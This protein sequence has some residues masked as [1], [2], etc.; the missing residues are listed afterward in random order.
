MDICWQLLIIGVCSRHLFTVWILTLSKWRQ[1]YGLFVYYFFMEL[2]KCWAHWSGWGFCDLVKRHINLSFDWQVNTIW[3][4][5]FQYIMVGNERC[6][7]CWYCRIVMTKNICLNHCDQSTCAM[8]Q[9]KMN[10]LELL[11]NQY[12]KS[13]NRKENKLVLW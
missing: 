3:W 4:L 13:K 1:L 9:K 8:Q 10:L 6:G 2:Q 12:R 7:C 11:T 5:I